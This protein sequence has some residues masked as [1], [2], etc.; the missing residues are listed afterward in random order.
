MGD[1]TGGIVSASMEDDDRIGWRG[2]QI[3]AETSK[4]Q[5]FALMIPVP[6]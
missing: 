6:E 4:V 3:L 1:F 5:T 2:P